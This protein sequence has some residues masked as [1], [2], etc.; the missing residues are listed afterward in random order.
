MPT[1]EP[2]PEP[3]PTS[4]L[5][6]ITDEEA[7][8]FAQRIAYAEGDVLGKL[9]I[10]SGGEIRSDKVKQA[11]YVKM[12]LTAL[13]NRIKLYFP[14]IPTDIKVESL[15]K[16]FDI[17]QDE[18]SHLLN[19]FLALAGFYGEKMKQE[20]IDLYN[21]RPNYFLVPFET[22]KEEPKPEEPKAETKESIE[23]KIKA[24]ELVFKY[25]KIENEKKIA[26][27]KINALKIILKY[28]K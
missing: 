18:N 14:Y 15:Q 24:L 27:N 16:V 22:K 2:T 20:Y 17:L 7:K 3:T 13:N 1:P 8:D 10:S 11:E 6:D 25:A 5:R 28:K 9:E 21:E 4:R 26:E 23:K 19:N 12:M